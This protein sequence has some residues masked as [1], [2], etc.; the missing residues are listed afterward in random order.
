MERLAPVTI[1]SNTLF[2][3]TSKLE[4]LVS[5][6]TDEFRPRFCLETLTSLYAD[7]GKLSRV[8]IAVP[9]VCFCDLPLSQ[10]GTHLSIYGNYGIGLS[11]DWGKRSGLTPVLYTYPESLL[12]QSFQSIV[13]RVNQVRVDEND[14]PEILDDIYDLSCFVK[15]Y[16]GDFW[17]RGD[18]LRNVRFYDEREWRYVPKLSH[19]DPFR[20]GMDKEQ[21]LDPE[22]LRTANAEIGARDQ[23]SFVPSDIRY[24]IVSRQDEIL[25]MMEELERIKRKYSWEDVRLLMSR[26]ISAEQIREDF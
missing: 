13:D 15:P 19:Q 18:V 22:L 4:H 16:E 20:F 9:M 26:V 5:I 23:L 1:S 14:Q 6:L 3:F 12:A 21:F 11:K 25:P 2:H 24:I 10:T 8:D 17:R 7:T